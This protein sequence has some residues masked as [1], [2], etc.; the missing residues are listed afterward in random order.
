MLDKKSFL[1]SNRPALPMIEELVGWK[2]ALVLLPYG[3][4]LREYR[5]NIHRVI[6]SRAALNLYHPMLWIETHRLLKHVSAKP[7]QLQSHVKRYA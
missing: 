6:G 4:R 1:Y 7:D 3:D 2:H 5:K